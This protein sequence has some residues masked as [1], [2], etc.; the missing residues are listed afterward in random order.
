MKHVF[1]SEEELPGAVAVMRVRV[2]YGE[3]CPSA[4]LPSPGHGNRLVIDIASSIGI[5]PAGMVATNADEGQRIPHFPGENLVESHDHGPRRAST[6][7]PHSFS[8]HL[9]HSLP[10]VRPQNK[11]VRH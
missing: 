4:V 9:L 7:F 5:V 6:H 10:A 11:L 1:M 8:P 2:D 3:P